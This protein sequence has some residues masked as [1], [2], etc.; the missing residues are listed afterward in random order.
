VRDEQIDREFFVVKRARV[1]RMPA[2]PGIQ[3]I[4]TGFKSL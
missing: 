4:C 3:L 2:D 1:D